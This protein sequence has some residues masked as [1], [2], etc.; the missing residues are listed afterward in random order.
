MIAGASDQPFQTV[1]AK[2]EFVDC[3]F[4]VTQDRQLRVGGRIARTG[5]DQVCVMGASESVSQDGHDVGIRL[6]MELHNHSR[7]AHMLNDLISEKVAL[8]AVD[9]A[10][11]ESSSAV[12]IGEPSGISALFDFNGV[13]SRDMG[14]NSPGVRGDVEGDHGHTPRHRHRVVAVRRAEVDEPVE[15]PRERAMNL[16]L[17]GAKQFCDWGIDLG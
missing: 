10:E 6:L 13:Q 12:N 17:V 1:E 16:F 3:E 11:Y 9:V 14:S 4:R 15:A 7:S 8:G 5:L 2:T